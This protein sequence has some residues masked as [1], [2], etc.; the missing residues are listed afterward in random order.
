MPFLA[1]LML[2]EVVLLTTG[3][4]LIRKG[5]LRKFRRHQCAC[6]Y[7][8]HGLQPGT[9]N[10]P[11]CGRVFSGTPKE[12]WRRGDRMVILGI[13]CLLAATIVIPILVPLLFLVVLV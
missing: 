11:E 13:A 3:I 2:V 5:D 8:R 7:P 6:G 9:T 12:H 10:C 1:L 4:V